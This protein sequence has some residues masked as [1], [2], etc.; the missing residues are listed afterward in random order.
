MTEIGNDGAGG[1]YIQ[2]ELELSL[3]D[4]DNDSDERNNVIEDY[5]EIAGKL[6]EMA[7]SHR[8]LFYAEKENEA[9]G[10]QP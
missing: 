2:E 5:P 10:T 1:K 3:F 6:L 8:D 4:L 9:G 7:E